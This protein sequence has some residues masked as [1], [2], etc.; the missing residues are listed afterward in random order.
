MAEA[1][2]FGDD[3]STDLIIPGR[4]LVE[5][6]PESLAEHAMEGADPEFAEKVNE[7]DVIVGGKNF[8]CGSSREHAPIALKA[9]GISGIIAESFARIFYRNAINQG[10]P[11]LT[12]E[13]ISKKFSTG[14]EIKVDWKNG[15]IENLSTGESAETQPLP[16]LLDEIVEAGGI[17]Q[18]LKEK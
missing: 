4:Y 8:G 10:I 2:I 15:E 12:S 5:R 9:A 11:V 1:W 16:P 6:D 18:Y 17:L 3:V 14:D 13:N 7:G